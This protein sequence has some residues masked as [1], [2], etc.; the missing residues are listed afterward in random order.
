VL[1][2]NEADWGMKRTEYRN[3]TRELAT[4]LHMNYAYGVEFVEVDPVF[5]LETERIHLSN[6]E[7]DR[8]LRQD[9]H[10]L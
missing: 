8:R 4:A 2:L 9:L 7:Q 1:V 3:V 10:V 5:D 6:A